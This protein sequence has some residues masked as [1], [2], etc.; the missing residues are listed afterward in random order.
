MQDVYVC[1][2]QSQVALN[3]QFSL[4]KYGITKNLQA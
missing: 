3:N 4:L 1:R 2:N